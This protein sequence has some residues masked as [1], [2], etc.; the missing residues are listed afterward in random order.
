MGAVPPHAPSYWPPDAFAPAC[1]VCFSLGLVAPKAYQSSKMARQVTEKQR[2]AMATQ[3]GALIRKW[4]PW[5][6]E[7]L[8]SSEKSLKGLT[9]GSR[10]MWTTS[11][12]ASAPSASTRRRTCGS[13]RQRVACRRASLRA[14][15][16]PTRSRTSRSCGSRIQAPAA[17]S[18]RNSSRLRLVKCAMSSMPPICS[19]IESS[20]M[21]FA[22]PSYL[23]C[24]RD[25]SCRRLACTM[26]D[27]ESV[28]G[29]RTTTTGSVP[30]SIWRT[31]RFRMPVS[32]EVGQSGPQHSTTTLSKRS[33]GLLRMCLMAFISGV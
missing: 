17:S 6:S 22:R 28:N 14:S 19:I 23:R 13:A 2:R 15:S 33:P 30:S 24:R 9:K 25:C 18:A 4:T 8:S 5:T 10:M 32:T 20:S 12:A 29:S 26:K 16:R 31:G 1:S 27:A 3:P 11:E 21:A 7:S